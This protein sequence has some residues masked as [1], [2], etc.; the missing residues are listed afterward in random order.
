MK[1]KLGVIQSKGILFPLIQVTV[2]PG[3]E[4]RI[5]RIAYDEENYK[6]ARTSDESQ[7]R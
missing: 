5:G 3:A 4:Q 2:L 7:D 6:L 1:A